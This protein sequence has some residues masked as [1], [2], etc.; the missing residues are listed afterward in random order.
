MGS[1]LAS[2]QFTRSYRAA[3]WGESQ[4]PTRGARMSSALRYAPLTATWGRAVR[5]VSLLWLLS[6]DRNNRERNPPGP[7][8]TASRSARTSPPVYKSNRALSPLLAFSNRCVENLLVVVCSPAATMSMLVR[9]RQTS[10][11][12]PGLSR[13]CTAP[14]QPS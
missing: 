6:S 12:R 9:H 14:E 3:H 4:A 5:L 1:N 13:V 8:L 7:A 10:I 11:P 2:A